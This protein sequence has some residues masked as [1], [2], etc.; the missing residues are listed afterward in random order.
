MVT[1]DGILSSV[2]KTL[3]DI[4]DPELPCSIVDLGLVEAVAMDENGNVDITLLPTFTGC[5]ALDMIA[6]DVTRLVSDLDAVESCR[7]HWVFDPPWSTDRITEAGRASLKA[8]GVTVPSCGGDASSSGVQLRT[9]AI[10][11]PWCGSRDT[12]MD[13]PFGPTRCR[14][15]QYCESCRN[16]FEDMKRLDHEDG[17]SSPGA[18]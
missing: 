14:T 13:S 3:A 4:P 1:D 6:N 11:C 2:R 15:I 9:S 7:V 18:G 16:T 10:A 17:T 8:H 12:R 5:P